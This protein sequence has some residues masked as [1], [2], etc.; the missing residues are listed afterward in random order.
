MEVYED[1][2]NLNVICA[3]QVHFYYDYCYHYLSMCQDWVIPDR[4]T[5]SPELVSCQAAKE[6][7]I[8]LVDFAIQRLQS[9]EKAVERRYLRPPLGFR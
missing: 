8:D 4:A 1:T 2:Y 9:F 5:E 6:A 3:L 7:S